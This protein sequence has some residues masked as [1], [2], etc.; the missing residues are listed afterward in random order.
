LIADLSNG[1]IPMTDHPRDVDLLQTMDAR[2][3]AKEFC[4]ITGFADEEWA[5]SWFA[6]AIMCGWDHHYWTTPEYKAKV[7][8]VL[9]SADRA[10]K[11]S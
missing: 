4:R 5:V 9:G 2:V 6:N 8:A 10:E 3:W 11:V 1:A 7:A